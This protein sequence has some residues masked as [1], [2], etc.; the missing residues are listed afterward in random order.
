MGSQ[1]QYETLGVVRAQA[2]PDNESAEF[3]VLIRSDLKGQGLGSQLM[4][5]IIRY[6]RQRGVRRIAGDVLVTNERML[7]LAASQGFTAEPAREGVVR[8]SLELNPQAS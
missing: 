5:K 1:G 3:A 8:V 6:C 2:D 4:E 7:Q